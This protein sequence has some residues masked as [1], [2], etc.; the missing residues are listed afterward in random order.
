V[1]SASPLSSLL[2]RRLVAVLGTVLLLLTSVV[3][4][5]VLPAFAADPPPGL[6]VSADAPESVLLGERAEITLT[7]TNPADGPELFNL[8]FRYVLPEG[9]E[10]AGTDHPLGDPEVRE[11]EN[12]ETVLVWVNVSDL[13]SGGQQQLS[14]DVTAG[15]DVLPVGSAFDT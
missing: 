4:A 5:P 6:A 15:V 1:M 8:S 3:A 13:P 10:Y 14:F 11:G 7:A 9:V 12:G 2:A